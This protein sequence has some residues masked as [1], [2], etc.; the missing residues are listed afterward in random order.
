MCNDRGN[1]YF[2][3]Y[4]YIYLK[5][6]KKYVEDIERNILYSKIKVKK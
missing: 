2:R 5:L 1:K 3:G 4:Y 6:H